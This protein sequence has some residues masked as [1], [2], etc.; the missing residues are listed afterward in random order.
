MKKYLNKGLLYEWFNASKVPIFI[1]LITWGFVVY[2]IVQ[3][4]IITVRND[5]AGADS[6]S[7][8][9]VDLSDYY[10]LGIIFLAIYFFSSGVSK[11]NTLM[12]LCSGPYTKKQIKINELICLIITLMLFICTYL[13][14]AFT[15]YI[16]YNELLLIV[17]WFQETII[18]EVVR[19]F[20]F[21]ILGIL[22]MITIDLLFS[23]S[24]ISYIG[25]IALGIATIKIISKIFMVINYFLDFNRVMYNNIFEKGESN[26][27]H[28]VNIL[29]S[30]GYYDSSRLEM[31]TNGIIVLMII[32]A[33]MSCAFYILEKKSKLETSGKVFSS[34][35]SENIIILY[36]S[37]GIGATI[38][39]LL[40]KKYIT[41]VIYRSG[42]YQPLISSEVI[43]VLSFDT[44]CIIGITIISYKMLKKILKRIG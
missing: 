3:S 35:T 31:I 6:S 21:G 17:K 29:F 10:I 38:N 13:Y 18:I 20:L 33:L 5:I 34:K 36:L 11:R 19:I 22:L 27:E 4:N 14:I 37:L 7:F 9:T 1:G 30:R 16:K 15:I 26:G 32:I 2:S 41:N 43:K 40:T 28:Y 12:F 23:N 44:I 25:M 42:E 24:I 39:L 8:S